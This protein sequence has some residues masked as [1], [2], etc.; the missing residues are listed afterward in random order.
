MN[1]SGEQKIGWASQFMPVLGAIKERFEKEKPL[2]GQRIGMALHVEAKTACLV[3]TLAAGGADRKS[4][5]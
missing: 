4:V 3:R 2:A 5:V 1:H